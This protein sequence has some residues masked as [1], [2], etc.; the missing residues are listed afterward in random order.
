MASLETL[1]LEIDG[2]ASAATNGIASLMTS[3]SALGTVVNNQLGS[4]RSLSAILKDIRS[5]AS[6]TGAWKG[7]SQLASPSMSSGLKKT[8]KAT[9]DF[10]KATK[11]GTINADAQGNLIDVYG[12]PID[13]P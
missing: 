3:L 9:S 5:T 11:L 13:K 2:N 7:I 1:T 12:Q 10:A 4:L 8:A 6:S